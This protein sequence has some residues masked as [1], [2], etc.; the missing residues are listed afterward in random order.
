M[1]FI[2]KPTTKER[3]SDFAGCKFS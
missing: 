1:L 3:L 2:R